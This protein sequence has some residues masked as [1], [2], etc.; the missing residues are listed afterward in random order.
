MPHHLPSPLTHRLRGIL[1][2]KDWEGPR[3][4]QGWS[5]SRPANADSSVTHSCLEIHSFEPH[6]KSSLCGS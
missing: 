5:S 6:K 4:P 3:S 2:L 1:G